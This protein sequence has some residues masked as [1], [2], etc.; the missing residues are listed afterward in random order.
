MNIIR[1]RKIMR[2]MFSRFRQ[3]NKLFK[4]PNL[5]ADTRF[6]SGPH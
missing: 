6:H 3:P 5:L 1:N 2:T 4:T